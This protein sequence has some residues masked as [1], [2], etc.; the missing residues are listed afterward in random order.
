M[1]AAVAFYAVLALS[2]LLV[3]AV[4]LMGY[5]FGE[6]AGRQQISQW[7]RREVGGQAGQTIIHLLEQSSAVSA[8][9]WSGLVSI[10][11]VLLGASR[12]IVV[13]QYSLNQIW[14]V[15]PKESSSMKSKVLMVVKKRV[16]AFGLVLLL[17][18][19]LVVS[20]SIETAL[21]AL[22]GTFDWL[23]FSWLV[24]EIFV[25]ALSWTLLAAIVAVIYSFVPDVKIEWR[26]AW[27]GA[28][29]TAGLLMV[30]KLLFAWYLSQRLLTST[31]GAAGS[32]VALL[33]WIYLSAQTFFLGAEL[34]QAYARHHGKTLA[35]EA[36]AERLNECSESVTSS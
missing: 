4:T 27:R 19:L 33:V 26:L 24:S 6:E 36:H 13:L 3:L 1:G 22:G 12:L 25:V 14:E 20:L 28:M 16:T 32:V 30:G 18:L 5:A 10:I 34:V 21:P 11:L 31:Y 8:M 17:S 35:P 23:P 7:V 2:P 9:S 29:V 15:Q